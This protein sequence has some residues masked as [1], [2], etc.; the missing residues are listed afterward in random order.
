MRVSHDRGRR[1]DAHPHSLP[2]AFAV[3]DEQKPGHLTGAGTIRASLSASGTQ[4]PK[5]GFELRSG[6][7][8]QGIQGNLTTTDGSTVVFVTTSRAGTA[9]TNTTEDVYIRGPL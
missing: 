7:M 9:D 2:A 4:L 1:V 8:L 5:G 6:T 3:L